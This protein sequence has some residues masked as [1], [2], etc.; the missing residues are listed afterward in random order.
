[1]PMIEPPSQ[2]TI[3]NIE[4]RNE[5]KEMRKMITNSFFIYQLFRKIQNGFSPLI[6]ICG[7]QR[8]GKS[9]IALWLCNLLAEM[10][11]KPFNM[12]K[13]T[14]YEPL[15]AIEKLEEKSKEAIFIDEASDIMDAREWYDQTHHA[16]RSM[17]NT[18]AY[19]TL[20][21]IFVSPF[22]VDID[23]SVRKHFD[24]KI[25]VDA[26]GRFKC[27]KYIKKY[28]QEEIKKVTEQIF[29]DDMGIKL[30]DLPTQK[31]EDY[32]NFSIKEKEK[33]RKRRYLKGKGVKKSPISRLLKNLR[34]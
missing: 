27:F 20:M 9:F 4:M 21:Y 6:V 7:S 18:Q 25:R 2:E 10:T 5:N 23:K 33:I 22:V 26:R 11:G 14:F 30:S 3:F 28:G 29:L 16:L 34:S 32:L 19:K 15:E 17:I 8:I 24:F 31:W 12:R 1:M 13:N